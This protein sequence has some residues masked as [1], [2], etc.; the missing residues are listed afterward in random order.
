MESINWAWKDCIGKE[1]LKIANY[2]EI[3][4]A[5]NRKDINQTYFD[6]LKNKILVIIR[7]FH[8]GFAQFNSDEE[9]LLKNFKIEFTLSYDAILKMLDLERGDIGVVPYTYITYYS[10][11]MPTMQNNY[12]LSNITDSNDVLSII[13]KEKN[14]IKN[15]ELIK[16]FDQLKAKGIL[17]KIFQKYGIEETLLEK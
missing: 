7:G 3:Y 16:L 14:K 13:S 11:F 4:I 15:Q 10:K 2:K 1:I 5:K 17:K 9:Y 12:F 8:Y 6:N